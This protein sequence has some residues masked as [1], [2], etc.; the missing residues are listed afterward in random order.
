MFLYDVLRELGWGMKGSLDKKVRKSFPIYVATNSRIKI[1]Q[2]K[3]KF[4][5]S[6]N[7]ML[8]F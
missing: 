5:N 7:K 6:K 1:G 8:S 2:I 4:K 3:S